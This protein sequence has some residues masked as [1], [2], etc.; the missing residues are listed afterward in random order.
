[1][2]PD[3]RFEAAFLR[4]ALLVGLIREREVVAWADALVAADAEPYALLADVAL[5]RPELTT[6]REALRPLAESSDDA[7]VADALVAF[8]AND[9]EARGLGIRDRVRVLV[10]LCREKL[11]AAR[12]TAAV[13]RFDEQLM[14]ASAGIS[15]EDTP[16]ERELDEFLDSIRTPSFY[17]L[18]P[19]RRDES[20]ALL[21]A[22]S[23]K[24]DRDRLFD[25][26]TEPGQAWLLGD[27][28]DATPTLIVNEA[29]WRMIVDEFSPL[30]L[31]S[32]IPYA[33]VPADAVVIL[34]ESTVEPMGM[35]EAAVLV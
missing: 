3:I 8:V 22:L 9:S 35:T 23:R 7:H 15:I 16:T 29:L 2:I 31:P 25:L 26:Q 18:S 21:A 11:L 34:D 10:Q 12:L 28:R 14:L 27:R 17:R 24:L 20:A 5:A 33:R 13:E 1:M 32:R 30:P 19:T 6:I 4:A